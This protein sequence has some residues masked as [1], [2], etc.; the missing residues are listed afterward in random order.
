MIRKKIQAAV[1]AGVMTLGF[2][3]DPAA[4]EGQQFASAGVGRT[5]EQYM[6]RVSAVPKEV[7]PAYVS[8]QGYAVPKVDS[9]LNVR[10]R[11]SS[12]STVV[13][14]LKDRNIA[15]VMS[16]KD[17]WA[18]IQ[19]GDVEGYVNEQYLVCG[20]EIHAYAEQKQYPKTAVI[21]ADALKVRREPNLKSDVLTVAE[22][23]S[24]YE[25]VNG[26]E[27]QW[28][29][30]KIQNGEGYISKEH[31]E[32]GYDFKEAESAAETENTASSDSKKSSAS[33]TSAKQK[34]SVSGRSL[35]SQ[36][37]AYAVKYVGNPYVYGG[38]SLT[39]GTDC[40]GF[41]MR[42]YEHFGYRL[43]RTSAAQAGNGREISL[44]TIQPGDLLFYRNGGRINHVTMYIG[45][46]KVVHASNSAPYPKGGI[47]ISSVSY[48]TPC[49][50]VRIIK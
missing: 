49:K 36:I 34:V 7:K 4:A 21:T 30:V 25:I 16:Q 12:G 2:V 13:G 15:K 6:D 37:A 11:P 19:S 17:G 8:Y 3:M 40:S 32:L 48:R 33:K 31:I 42:V 38:T 50:A 18:R 26:R 23:G 46:G 29:K 27:A 1:G 44:S 9:H 45:N 22:K 24:S 35:G 39:N 41:V 5:I 43:S 10:S 28:T 20:E 47:K 14:E